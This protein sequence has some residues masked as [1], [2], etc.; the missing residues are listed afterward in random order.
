LP[1]GGSYVPF[2]GNFHGHGPGGDDIFWFDPTATAEKMWDFV[3]GVPHSTQ[4]SQNVEG[5]YVPATGDYLVD[6]F[7]DIF[8]LRDDFTWL[9]WDW[10]GCDASFCY[11]DV[12]ESAP[13]AGATQAGETSAVEVGSV[14]V[15][16]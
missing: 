16:A 5:S 3:R 1:A 2:S 6:G 15:D 12:W 13:A 9:L 7:H 10:N 11:F 4:P 8:W 14:I